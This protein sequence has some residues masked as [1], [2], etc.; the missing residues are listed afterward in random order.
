MS[1]LLRVGGLSHRALQHQH[2]LPPG[3]RDRI[4]ASLGAAS[5]QIRRFLF[6]S[7]SLFPGTHVHVYTRLVGA[8][9]SGGSYEYMAHLSRNHDGEQRRLVYF[10]EDGTKIN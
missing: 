1:D 3:T 4:S 2:G 8:V 9:H 5:R 10:T 6:S 7:V